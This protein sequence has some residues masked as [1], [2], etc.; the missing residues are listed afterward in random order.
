[1]AF[2]RDFEIA[3]TGMVVSNAYH[4]INGVNVEKR[5]VPFENA[6]SNWDHDPLKGSTGYAASI[7]ISVYSSKQAR[8]DMKKPVGMI[9]DAMPEK[10]VKLRFIF[11]ASSSDSSL[12][13]AY[14]YLK[15]T[16][17]YSSATED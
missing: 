6:G 10:P 13:Q 14:N 9:N 11:D 17:Y 8:D 2:I 3:S 5:I 4:V 12:V 7:F 1:M 15:T 16:E